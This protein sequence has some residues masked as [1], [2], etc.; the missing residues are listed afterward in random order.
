MV[1]GFV[2]HTGGI[3]LGLAGLW[4]TGEKTVHYGLLL[5]KRAKISAFSV[6]FIF[7]AIITGIP[8]L[9]ISLISLQNEV[10]QTSVGDLI[11]SN[12]VDT[13]I[14]IGTTTLITGALLF[15]KKE[16]R[17][18][19][20]MLF[21]VALSMIG[22]FLLPGITQVS[23]ALLIGVYLVIM[24][25]LWYMRAPLAVEEEEDSQEKKESFSWIIVKLVGFSLL[26][27]FAAEIAVSSAKG[28][29]EMHN[30]PDEFLGKT[31]FALFTSIPEFV[32]SYHA[33]KQKEFGLLMGNAMG[34]VLQQGLFT[35]GLL[36][37]LSRVPLTLTPVLDV[38]GF[39]M[40]GFGLIGISLYFFN[41][42]TR[43]MGASM[44][45]LGVLFMAHEVYTLFC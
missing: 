20:H 34:A 16:S 38:L 17:S 28:L 44:V 39:M 4:Y 30:W 8:E 19:L 1:S 22:I 3:L 9:V 23:G 15:T 6:G 14:V 33:A 26:L 29:A 7:I 11:G 2:F 35:L 42:V 13:T 36:A 18:L 12:F 40:V 24:L 10:P 45:G 25:Y 32:I 43:T 5:A 31:V 41:K 27:A 37:L 21:L